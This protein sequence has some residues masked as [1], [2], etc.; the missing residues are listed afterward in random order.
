MTRQTPSGPVVVSAIVPVNSELLE[1][2]APE[3]GPIH[4]EVLRP[5][6]I[7]AAN[8][9][10]VVSDRRDYSVVQQ[11][12]TSQRSIPRAVNPF[13]KL[14]TGIVT[15][16]VFDQDRKASEQSPTRLIASFATRPSLLNERLFSPLGD[17]GSVAATALLI[18]GAV[19]LVIEFGA[20]VTGI[21]LT[22]TITT[23]V[24]DLYEATQHVQ[25]G[26]LT[27]R[28]RVPNRDQ[29]AALGE[30]FNS[31]MHSVSTL[32]DEQRKRQRLENELSIAQEV[33]QQLFPHSLPKLPGV[34]LEAICR[35]ARVVS[36][37]YYDFIRV[38]PTI[39][40]IALAD[41]SGK[42]ISAALLMASV[43]AALRSDV[44]RYREG[45]PGFSP[46]EIDTAKITSHLNRHLF[47]NTSD[48][49]YATFFFAVYDTETRR[50]KYTNAGHP[51]PI[52][53]CGDHVALL[54]TG[55]TVVGLFNDVPYEQGSIEI[56]PGGMLIAYSDGLVEPE[57]KHGEEFG[58]ERLIE[59]IKLHRQ[60]SSHLIA[61]AMMRAAEGWS[62]SPEQADDMTV[63][64]SRFSSV[65]GLNE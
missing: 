46:S 2:L 28:V 44:L 57:N 27:F 62:G 50:L 26:D 21:V 54:E 60:E 31:M 47:R 19:F 1:T 51:P 18:V 48:E 45:Q 16:D 43:Q 35:P 6:N 64:V 25:A 39:L 58:T 14:I 49:R 30:S 11:I 5:K 12:D 53:L 32:I 61:D 22:R 34:E 55:G 3:L 7:R 63:I 38:T 9:V 17:L 15:L 40:A 8:D 33:Q 56:Q 65:R 36:G 20:L 10:S 37:D 41:I 42:G 29:L 4:L 13:D 52:Y 24:D 23:A 59:V